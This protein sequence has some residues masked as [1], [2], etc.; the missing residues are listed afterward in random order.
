MGRGL[1]L[2]AVEAEKQRVE[3]KLLELAKDFDLA[4]RIPF[5]GQLGGRVKPGT[6]KWPTN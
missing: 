6:C 5:A 3:K 4:E 1:H 2:T